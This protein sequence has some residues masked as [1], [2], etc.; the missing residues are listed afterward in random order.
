MSSRLWSTLLGYVY[1]AEGIAYPLCILPKSFFYPWCSTESQQL[2]WTG[3][4]CDR[5]CLLEFHAEYCIKRTC[6]RI[7]RTVSLCTPLSCT[8]SYAMIHSNMPPFVF[9]LIREILHCARTA[10]D[11]QAQLT[12][13]VQNVTFFQWSKAL[14]LS[15][16]SCIHQSWCFRRKPLNV[17]PGKYLKHFF[18]WKKSISP[19]SFAVMATDSP[20]QAELCTVQSWG[21]RW[22]KCVTFWC[23]WGSLFQWPSLVQTRAAPWLFCFMPHAYG[24]KARDQANL[25]AI[26]VQPCSP[27]TFCMLGK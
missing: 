11:F 26:H 21:R 25:T 10:A 19:Q 8:H 22:G 3:L 4:G 6:S 7:L 9:Q 20:R 18:S 2:C 5:I 17:S 14:T 27:A 1:T 23:V 16:S 13:F 15:F 24:P 12:L